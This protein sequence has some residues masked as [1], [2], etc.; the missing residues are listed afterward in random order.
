MPGPVTNEDAIS[1][2]LQALVW[3]LNEP[4]RADRLLAVTGLDPHDLRI[5]VG[6]PAVLSAALGFLEGH[7]P[8]LIA[9]AAALGVPPQ[10]L[11]AAHYRLEQV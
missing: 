1:L 5:R 10:A 2:A 8:D 3:T 4:D 11:V 6:E 9:C 7:E